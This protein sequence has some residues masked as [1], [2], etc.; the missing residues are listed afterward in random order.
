MPDEP[1]PR[2]KEYDQAIELLTT[3]LKEVEQ[4]NI[5][6][7]LLLAE[8]TDGAM[9]GAT[10]AT[11]NQFAVGG[12]MIAWALRRMGFTTFDDIKAIVGELP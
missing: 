11:Q 7:V 10:T 2:I 5:M 9:F 3:V 1:L 6:S 8:T 12:F 4:G